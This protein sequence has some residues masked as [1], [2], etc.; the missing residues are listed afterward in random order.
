MTLAPEDLS[1]PLNSM[2]ICIPVHTTPSH[3]HIKIIKNKKR[4]LKN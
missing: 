2:G 4:P 1:S 3:P